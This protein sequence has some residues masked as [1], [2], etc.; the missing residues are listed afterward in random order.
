[1]EPYQIENIL[2]ML[3]MAGA[4]ITGL[5][6]LTRALIHWRGRARPAD[7]QRIAEAVEGLRDSVEATRLE[8]ADMSERL[9]FTE[10]VLAQVAGDNNPQRPRLP[11]A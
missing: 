2:E 7:L 1:M 9:E 4:T 10:R 5:W 3:I 6:I 8:V 11:Q